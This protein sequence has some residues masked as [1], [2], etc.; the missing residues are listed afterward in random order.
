MCMRTNRTRGTMRRKAS[1]SRGERCAGRRL[2]VHRVLWGALLCTVLAHTPAR[3]QGADSEDGPAYVY[4]DT[5]FP[6]ALV[7]ADS[8]LVGG[9][10]SMLLAVP[11]ASRSIRLTAPNPDVWSI[12]P[13]TRSLDVVAG[14]TARV[15]MHFPYHYRIESEPFGADVLIQHLD[16]G[17]SIGVTPLLYRSADPVEGSILVRRVGHISQSI[18]PGKAVWNRHVVHLEPIGEL[19][20][21]IQMNLNPPRAQR[22]WIDY[23]ALGTALAA[24]AFAVHY[25]FKADDLADEYERTR[26]EALMP[27][28]ETQ[29]FRAA[30]AFGVMQGGVA[31]FALRLVLR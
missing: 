21:A 12:A 31:V 8:L 27:R 6:E 22:K 29:D 9:A 17:R 14:D 3:A 2:H 18:Q 20:T 5:N 24:G 11:A 15:V 10:S 7:F 26:D 4:I 13:I 1:K 30:V 23:A 16:Q 28:I 19:D 25:K